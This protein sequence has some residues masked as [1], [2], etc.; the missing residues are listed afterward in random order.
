MSTLAPSTNTHT[1]LK[2]IVI[3]G[4]CG[5][6]HEIA[7]RQFFGADIDL[8]PAESFES[9]F[10]QAAN[11][12]NVDAAVMAIENSIAGSIL[13][14]YNLLLNS[15]LCITGEVLLRIQQN[16]L[17]LPGVR[18]E[19]LKEIHSHPMALAQCKLFLH[20]FPKVQLI[21]SDDTAESAAQIAKQG[22]RNRAAIGSTLAA[23]VYG[24]NVLAPEIEDN[25]VNFT[26]FLALQPRSSARQVAQA[27]KVSVCFTA[28]HTPGSLSR[29]LT[30][31]AA[32]S[33]N[34]TKIQSVPLLGKVWEYRFFIDFTVQNP[35]VL[36]A[37][38]QLLDVMT[39]DLQILGIYKAGKIM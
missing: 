18:M 19:D 34:L 10:E 12:A 33:A 26:R 23:E 29:I 6:F 24:L 32:E 17:A 39:Q 38:L 11:P 3:Q 8:V 36:P 14:N 21:E 25:P 27:D 35:A 28:P 16:L 20:R 31:L 30:M 1:D 13:P 37:A 5:A 9:L 22:L 2:R 7:A 4:V 15:D